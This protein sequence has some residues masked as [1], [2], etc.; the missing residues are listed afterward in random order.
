MLIRELIAVALGG[1]CGASGRLVLTLAVQNGLGRPNFPWGIMLCNVLG[2]LLIGLAAG[3]FLSKQDPSVFWR[4]FIM[5]GVL[6]GFTTFSSFSLDTWMLLQTGNGFA[7]AA[8]VLLSLLSCLAATVAGLYI[9]RAV[10][11]N[12]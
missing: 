1:A 10:L 5:V 11:M 4:A 12:H 2:C 9:M 3:W 7:A 6:G 8:N